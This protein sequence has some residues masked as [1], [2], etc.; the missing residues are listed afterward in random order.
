MQTQTFEGGLTNAFG[1]HNI[2]L[3]STGLVKTMTCFYTVRKYTAFSTFPV[4]PQINA[5][6]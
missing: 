5:V 2:I 6:C 1:K 4:I 3:D